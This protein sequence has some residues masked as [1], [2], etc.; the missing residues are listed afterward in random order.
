MNLPKNIKNIINGIKVEGEEVVFENN[1]FIILKDKKHSIDSYHYTAWIKKD[2]RNLLE[3]N[4]NIL[5]QINNIKNELENKNLINSDDFIFI[6]FPPSIWRLHIHFVEKNH[7]FEAPY[8]EIF[9]L[10][11]IIEKINNDPD[12]Y[13]KNVVI[14]SK[15]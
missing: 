2:I 10:N 1:N 15:I 14:R 5:D 9:F 3:V 8:Y 7:I 11:E 13:L 6:H 12:Y 4:K